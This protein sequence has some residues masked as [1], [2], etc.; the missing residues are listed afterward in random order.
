MGVIGNLAYFFL[1]PLGYNNDLGDLKPVDKWHS[2]L[3]HVLRLANRAVGLKSEDF[4]AYLKVAGLMDGDFRP[5][6]EHRQTK[7]RLQWIAT[8]LELRSAPDRIE[9][10]THTQSN[11]I[12][13]LD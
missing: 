11:L 13:Y 8:P 6:K 5:L 4:F 12:K 3:G 7:D 9:H 1:N 2:L 10:H